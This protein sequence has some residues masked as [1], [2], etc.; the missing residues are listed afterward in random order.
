MV[1]RAVAQRA[2]LGWYGK[3]T[4]ILTKGWGSWIFLAEIV[5]N[6]PLVADEPLKTSCGSCEICLHACPTG[7]LPVPYVLDNT[8]CISYLTIELRGSI[9]IELRPLMG[10]LIFGCD[11][12]Q[13]VCPVNQLAERRLGLRAGGERD[14]QRGRQL[15]L[16][17]VQPRREFQPR[18]GIGS[19]PELIPLLSLTEEEFRERFRHSPI[20]R[21][22]RR[23]FLRNV[24][25]ALGNSGDPRAVPALINAL[26]DEEP[27]IRGHAAWALGRIGGESA[28]QALAEGLNNENDEEVRK[29]IRCA[30]SMLA[31]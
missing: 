1:D 25:V 8:R 28:R 14:G 23:G 24:C 4:N 29:E 3:N 27:L 30:L 22:K 11:I 18:P 31:Q 16:I 17:H 10:N 19:S 26:H 6:L 2:G 9:P 12:C 20:K 15:P 21:A 7:A 13:Q 5:T